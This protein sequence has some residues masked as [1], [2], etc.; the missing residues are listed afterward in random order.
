MTLKYFA[1]SSLMNDSNADMRNPPRQ[2][3]PL[4]CATGRP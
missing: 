2:P 4:R 1:R 3:L